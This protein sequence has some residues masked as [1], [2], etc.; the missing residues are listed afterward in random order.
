MYVSPYADKVA[1]LTRAGHSATEISALLGCSVRAVVRCRR[2]TGTSKGVASKP[3]AP[4]TMERVKAMIAEGASHA[5]IGRTVGIHP[6]TVRRHF[7]NTGW[8]R[9][10]CNEYLSVARLARGLVD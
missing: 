5:E 8:T 2:L 4:E 6:T 9:E 1:E 7:P 10:Q 3:T